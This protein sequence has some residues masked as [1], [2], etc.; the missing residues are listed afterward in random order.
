MS[1]EKKGN[2][3]YEILFKDIKGFNKKYHNRHKTEWTTKEIQLI[4]T[5]DKPLAELSIELGRTANAISQ[6]RKEIRIAQ[7]NKKIEKITLLP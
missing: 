3:R 2:N 1:N 7:M 6:K 4:M 5:S